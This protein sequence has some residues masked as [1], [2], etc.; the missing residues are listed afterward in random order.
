MCFFLAVNFKSM[1]SHISLVKEHFSTL[2]AL[3]RTF[4]DMLLV[5]VLAH[6]HAI[7]V[8]KVAEA[9]AV[10]AASQ[11][12]EV[13]IDVGLGIVEPTNMILQSEN[14]AEAPAALCASDSKGV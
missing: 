1:N 10:E 11:V 8:D 12:L 5:A 4:H 2:C 9:A 3:P 6:G 13:G 7:G 14:V